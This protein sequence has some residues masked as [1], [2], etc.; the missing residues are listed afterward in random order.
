MWDSAI[1]LL[2]LHDFIYNDSKIT[3]TCLII[4]LTFLNINDVND[5]HWN[6][7]NNINVIIR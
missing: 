5:I 1:M 6:N 2:I 7:I 3:I 4:S